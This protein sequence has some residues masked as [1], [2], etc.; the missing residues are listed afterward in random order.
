MSFFK[1][2]RLKHLCMFLTIVT[3]EESIR[4]EFQ[5]SIALLKKLL[6]ETFIVN[7][8]KKD[9]LLQYVALWEDYRKH[10]ASKAII[11]QTDSIT[12]LCLILYND[13]NTKPILPFLNKII[14]L[15]PYLHA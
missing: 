12:S 4:Y 2:S 11:S 5:V 6:H 14:F 13:I 10:S 15:P 1:H 7:D 3:W 9:S 8:V